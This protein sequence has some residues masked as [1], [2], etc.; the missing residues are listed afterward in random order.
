MLSFHKIEK[1]LAAK[2]LQPLATENSVLI[3]DILVV[4]NASSPQGEYKNSKN[5]TRQ[6]LLDR[7]IASIKQLAETAAVK[8]TTK[9]FQRSAQNSIEHTQWETFTKNNKDAKQSIYFVKKSCEHN[10]KCCFVI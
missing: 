8:H 9:N 2:K 10:V 6:Q 3:R 7:V 5:E 1:R 4:Q